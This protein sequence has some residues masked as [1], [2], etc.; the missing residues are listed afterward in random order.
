MNM[1][2][3]VKS[4]CVL[5][6]AIDMTPWGS[7]TDPGLWRR[8]THMKQLPF[9]QWLWST[10]VG[11]W[12]VGEFYYPSYSGDLWR[13]L[14]SIHFRLQGRLVKNHRRT[15]RNIQVS[16]PQ[17]S[18]QQPRNFAKRECCGITYL[19]IRNYDGSLRNYHELHPI[20]FGT[21]WQKL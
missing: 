14:I 20:R 15:I 9:E 12:L 11:W 3:G 2:V 5:D 1:P 18:W 10:P 6:E 17:I 19:L 13:L 16:R 21:R 8:W 7:S 4:F